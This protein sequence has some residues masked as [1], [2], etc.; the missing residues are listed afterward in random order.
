MWLRVPSNQSILELRPTNE[1]GGIHPEKVR[2]IE[3]TGSGA[4]DQYIFQGDFDLGQGE[5]LYNLAIY[6]LGPRWTIH[7][8]E[9]PRH[10]LLDEEERNKGR[11]LAIRLARTL[12][13]I[14]NKD[15][16]HTTEWLLHAWENP[17]TAS[18]DEHIRELLEREA[19]AR[20]IRTERA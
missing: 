7:C 16:R 1:V 13:K 12:P 8:L 3:L 17:E 11:E 10:T 20:G 2:F 9:L 14:E 4:G 5:R 18:H 15:A 19:R 6:S